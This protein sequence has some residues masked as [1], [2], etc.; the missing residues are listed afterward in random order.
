M[1]AVGEA[2]ES[3]YA[4]RLMRPLKAETV[5]LQEYAHFR[6][7]D[8]H[9]GRLLAEGSQH[10]RLHSALGYL[11]PAEFATAWQQ[12][13]ARAPSVQLETPENGPHSWGHY[14]AVGG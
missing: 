10:K 9:L 4:E 6:E 11:T 12:R 5:T 2:T 1:A 13:Q 8:Q 7:A 3:G 14:K